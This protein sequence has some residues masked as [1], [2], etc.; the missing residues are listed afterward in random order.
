[1]NRLTLRTLT[2]VYM[3]GAAQRVLI[4]LQSAKFFKI[5]L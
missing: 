5:A 1:M 4:M 2:A 3:K